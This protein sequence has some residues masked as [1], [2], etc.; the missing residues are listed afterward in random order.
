VDPAWFSCNHRA[1][2]LPDGDKAFVCQDSQGL[3]DCRHGQPVA[4]SLL[5]GRWQRLAWGELARGDRLADDRSHVVSHWPGS[6]WCHI[7]GGE[8][9][10]LDE[11]LAGAGEIAEATRWGSQTRPSALAWHLQISR[12]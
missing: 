9:G 5:L 8:R 4:V 2:A 6:G 11:R 3:V 7:D 1:A 12:L 10:V